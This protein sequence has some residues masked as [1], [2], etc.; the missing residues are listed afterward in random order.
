MSY[1]P[2]TRVRISK[3]TLACFPP[4][5]QELIQQNRHGKAF[6]SFSTLPS[7]EHL[8]VGEGEKIWFVYGDK[9]SGRMEIES[10]RLLGAAGL[11]KGIGERYTCPAGTFVV[12]FEWFC[13]EPSLHVYNFTDPALPNNNLVAALT[14]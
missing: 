2:P 3:K 4:K 14:A 12:I 9:A 5:V 13:G 11:T 8:T 7:G 6:F 1:T 10:E